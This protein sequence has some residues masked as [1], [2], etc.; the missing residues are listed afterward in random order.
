MFYTISSRL[1]GPSLVLWSPLSI[2]STTLYQPLNWEYKNRVIILA[3]SQGCVMA[4]II[5]T[6]GYLV[7]SARLHVSRYNHL[8]LQ[9]T[10]GP[11]YQSI[12]FWTFDQLN[13]ANPAHNNIIERPSYLWDPGTNCRPPLAPVWSSRAMCT[14]EGTINT[15][16]KPSG[17]QQESV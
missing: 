13:I 12:I 8:F 11:S 1:H 15:R 6:R 16:P 17:Q 5:A 7:A 10:L 4:N 9:L 14:C 2:C 3:S